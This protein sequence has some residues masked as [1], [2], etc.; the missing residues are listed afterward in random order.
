[1]NPSQQGVWV[2]FLLLAL[3]GTGFY[4]ASSSSRQ[5]TRMLNQTSDLIISNLSVKQFNEEGQLVHWLKSPK[6]WHSPESDTH[7]F[8]YPVLA[9]KES[10]QEA[11]NITAKLAKADKKG[12]Q[13][14]FLQQ[15]IVQQNKNQKGESSTLKT[16]EL[17]YLPKDKL[18]QSN[19]AVS[20]EQEGSVVHSN[21][22]KAFLEE[23]RI[24]LLSK[25]R[26]TFEP[27]QHA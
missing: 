5:G 9:L 19:T 23:K 11:W 10:N 7:F 1:M 4:Y 24:V 20:F 18:A 15:V 8:K 12:Q 13:V 25:A 14:T 16:E 17:T 21:G 22:M 6:V 26:A 2:F 27:K 3:A